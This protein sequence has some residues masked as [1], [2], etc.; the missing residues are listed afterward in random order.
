MGKTDPL[1]DNDFSDFIDR[2]KDF[3]DSPKSWS[4]DVKAIDLLRT[5]NHTVGG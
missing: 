1:N 5:R 4:L 3:A 2:Q